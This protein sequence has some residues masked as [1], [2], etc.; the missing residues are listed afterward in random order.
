[1]KT[2]LEVFAPVTTST[3]CIQRG[4]LGE[5]VYHRSVVVDVPEFS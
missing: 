3:D 5:H 4:V 2:F 1:M